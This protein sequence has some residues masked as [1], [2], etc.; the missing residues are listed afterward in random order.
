[1]NLY[2][3]QFGIFK[4]VNCFLSKNIFWKFTRCFRNFSLL[5]N[6]LLFEAEKMAKISHNIGYL[7]ATTK[8]SCFWPCLLAGQIGCHANWKAGSKNIPLVI[9]SSNPISVYRHAVTMQSIFIS[10]DNL[11]KNVWHVLRVSFA[12]LHWFGLRP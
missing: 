8:S 9:W 10:F 4:C 7:K 3:L 11:H 12:N 2:T 5:L 6:K 1:M